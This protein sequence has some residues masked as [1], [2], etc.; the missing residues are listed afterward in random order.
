MSDT[1]CVTINS[2]KENG[3]KATVGFVVAT[4]ALGSGK[5]TM[6]FLST[7]GVWASVKDEAANVNE[8]GPFKPLTD[9]VTRFIAAGGRVIACAPCCK[10]REISEDQL[11]DGVEIAGGAVLVEWL[12]NGSPNVSY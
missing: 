4:A 9:L 11:F 2:C 10:K 7:D 3:D 6:V 5:D 1:F 12:S 8:G